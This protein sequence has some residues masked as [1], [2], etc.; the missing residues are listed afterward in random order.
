MRTLKFSKRLVSLLLCIAILM[1]YIPVTV[2]GA[3]SGNNPYKRI[4]DANTMNNWT[5]YFDLNN[6]TTKNAGGVWTDKSV[7]TDASAFQGSGITMLDS[8]KNFLTA[9]SA[10]AANKEVVGY[11]TVPTDTVLILDLSNS[12]EDHGAEQDLINAANEA[13]STLLKN[14]N[15]NRVGVVLYSGDNASTSSYSG[16]VTRILEIDR[17]TTTDSQGRYLNLSRY[18]VVSVNSNVTAEDGSALNRTKSFDGATY[19]QSGLWEAWKMFE[20]IPDSDTVIGPNNWQSGEA[21]MPIVVLMSDGDPSQATSYYNDVENSQYTSFGRTTY[22]SNVGNGSSSNMPAGQGFLVQLTASYIKSRIE[23]KYNVHGENGAGRS[24]F[25][26]LGFEVSGYSVAQSVLNPDGSTITDELWKDYAALTTGSLNVTVKGRNGNRTTVAIQKDSYVTD[27]HY[28]DGYFPA[29]TDGLQRAFGDIVDE[30]LLQS[31]YYPTHLEGG[32]P[33]FAGYVEFTDILGAYMEVKHINGILL[34][35]TLYDGHMMASKLAETGENGLGTPESPTAL[36]DAFIGAVKTRLGIASTEEA[37]N[38]VAMAYADGQLRYNGPTDWSNY[39]MWYAKAD[40]TFAGFCDKDGTSAMPEGAVYINQSYGFLGETTGSIKNSDMMY[41]SVQVRANIETGEQTVIWKIPAALVPMVTYLVTLSGTSVDNATDVTLTVE[42]KNVQPIRLVYET[43]LRADLNE[44]NITRITDQNHIAADGHTRMFWNNYFANLSSESH[45]DHITTMAEFKPNKENERFY[46][47][48]DSAVFKEGANGYEIVGNESLN[49]NGTYY[50]RRYIFEDGKDT[51]V[52]FYEKMS[53]ASIQAAIDN[54]YQ[55]DFETLD[56]NKTGAW[57][58]PKGTPARELQMYDEEK[59]D[60]SNPTR[61]AKMV[62]HPYLSEQNNIVAVDMNL[63]N[64]GLLLV[65]PA[66]GIKISKTVDIF[67]TGTSDTFKFRV[68]ASVSGSYDTWITAIDETPSGDPGTATFS[69]GVYE[70]TLK[71]DQTVWI[72]GLPAGTTYTVE[73]IS[74]NR[75]YKIKSVHVNNVSTGKVATGIVAQYFVDDVRFVNTAVG[76]G[77][78][79]ITKQVVDS[80]G[81]LVDVNNNVL[82]T[83]EIELKDS[84]NQA[85]SGTFQSSKGEITLVNGTYTVTLAEGESFVIRGIPEET[86]Y[87]VTET[88]IPAGFALD[89]VRSNLSGVIDG[90]AQALIVNTYTPTAADGQDVSV[91]IT[92]VITGNRTDWLPG[93]TYTFNLVRVSDGAV[94][95]TKTIAA[96]DVVKSHTWTLSGEPYATAG[97]Y[98]Y[99]VKEVVG[100]QGGI[101]YD[102]ATRRFRVVVQDEDMDGD[103]EVILVSNEMN[104]T[105]TG[106]WNVAAQF[107]NVYMPTGTASAVVHIQKEMTGN[108]GLNGYQFVLYD[109]DPRNSSEY[110]EIVRSGLTDATGRAVIELYYTANDVGNTYTYYL[111]EV[112]HGLKL[113]NIQY[114]DQVYT[115]VVTVKDDLDGTISAIVEIQGLTAGSTAP[116]FTN[117]YVPSTSD[118]ITLSGKKVIDGDR[119]LNLNEFAFVIE[120]ETVGAPMPAVTTVKNRVDGFFSFPAIEFGDSHKGNTYVYKIYEVEDAANKIGGFQYDKTVYTVT[121]T[122]VDNGENITAT[123]VIHNGTSNVD[124]MVFTNTYD[125]KDAEV[126][127]NGTKIL[128]GKKLTDQEFEFVLE[129]IT[130][131]APMPTEAT[132]KNDGKGNITLGKITFSKAGTYVYRLTEKDGGV[133]NYDYDE[134][135]YTV[136]VTVTDNSQGVLLAKVA[137]SKNGIDSTEIVFRNGFTPTA[138]SYDLHADFGGEKVLEGRPLEEGEFEFALMNARTGET[139]GETVFNG[140][141][142]KFAFPEVT[143]STAGIHHFKIVEVSG[144]EKGVTY[145]NTS[146][147]IRLEVVQSDSGVLS[148]Q[149]AQLHKGTV[150]VED[151]S[152]VPTEVTKYVNITDGGVIR[153]VNTYAADAAMVVLEGVKTLTGRPLQAGEFFFELYEDGKKLETVS[154]DEDGKFVF[155]AISKDAAGEYVYTVREVQGDAEHVTYDTTVYVV[156]VTLTDQQDGTFKVDYTYLKGTDEVDGVAFANVYTKPEEI[157]VTGEESDLQLWLTLLFVSGGCLAAV[158]VYNKKKREAEEN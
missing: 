103:L 127:L 50:H 67:E 125:A 106:A 17:Y 34:G 15:N 74:D 79:V 58:V 95:G 134:S 122:V 49:V 114:S 100:N 149:D 45:D 105:V 12:M 33:D 101:T 115:V 36:G 83:A 117:T 111:A 91:N 81:N 43:G 76:E 102:T 2:F 5:K 24:L 119:V 87:T 73:E 31:R 41:M 155:E 107:S 96:S 8:E 39:I 97:N 86:A 78:L 148:V 140:A 123:A 99:E 154:H 139:I 150:A 136:T 124:N 133:D 128:E 25:Y 1:T 135:V 55:S 32:N 19:M 158:T 143:L 68:T 21:R 7:F 16:A 104:T 48:F 14:N 65:T 137:L 51:P 52:F 129:A 62:F 94:I 29:T 90:S 151:V 60:P 47:T 53:K 153:F 59:A 118:Y 108:H 57:V 54:G 10:I 30:I 23:N 116:T 56:H 85:L 38:L 126:I 42:D 132:V 18:G 131:G 89:R 144:D 142:G 28:V 11:H 9:L 138:I 40:G 66:T 93:E 113:N 120:A 80:Q 109:Q 64:N 46:F 26:T 44:F 27:K 141:D 156:K 130:Q 20:E 110:S 147:H 70:V 37:R 35:S 84:Q 77:D 145:D 63:G 4:V 152:G 72:S 22:A 146:F 112:N 82:F 75:D 88:N 121:V 61:S 6:L 69:N 13:I 92:K 157:P 71:K 3:E 98:Y